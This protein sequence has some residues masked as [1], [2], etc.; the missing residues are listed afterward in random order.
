MNYENWW[1]DLEVWWEFWKLMNYENWWS[2]L[3]VWW[4]FWKLMNYENWWSLTLLTLLQ[5]NW[6]LS[7]FPEQQETVGSRWVG[8]RPPPP[9]TNRSCNS[10]FPHSSSKP[11]ELRPSSP[12]THPHPATSQTTSHDAY[13]LQ[14]LVHAIFQ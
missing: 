5:M 8:G 7:Q 2:D 10:I 12:K 11:Q 14:L 9:T 1:S 13:L 3:E 4:E 6:V